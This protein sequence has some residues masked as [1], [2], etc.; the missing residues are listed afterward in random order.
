MLFKSDCLRSV[1]ASDLELQL[2]SHVGI[3]G[4]L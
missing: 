4:D 2:C 3:K 1:N